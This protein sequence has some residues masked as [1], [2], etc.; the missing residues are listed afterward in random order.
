MNDLTLT[1]LLLFDSEKE[2]FDV[3]TKILDLTI[4]FLKDSGGFGEPLR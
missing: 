3:K 4:Q 1:Y 2:D